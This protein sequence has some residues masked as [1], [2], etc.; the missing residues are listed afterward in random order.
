VAENKRAKGERRKRVKE[1][2]Q[3]LEARRKKASGG[4]F[5]PERD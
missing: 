5:A 4:L 2:E 1:M 3:V